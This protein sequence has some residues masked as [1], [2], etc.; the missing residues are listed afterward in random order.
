MKI[1]L[2]TFLAGAALAYVCRNELVFFYW[3]HLH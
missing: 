3:E 1:A 2:W